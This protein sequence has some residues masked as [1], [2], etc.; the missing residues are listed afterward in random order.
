[1]TTPLEAALSELADIQRE[2]VEWR[3]GS[4]LVL[5][6][7]GSGK[8]QVLTCRI[9]SMLESSKGQNFRLLALTFTN[10]AADEMKGRVATFAPGLEDRANIG[11]FHSFCGQIL[12]QHGVHIGVSPDFAIYSA[13]DDRKAVLHDALR[14]AQAEGKDA[15]P[16]DVKY[17][18]LIDRMK[19]RLID[20]G[21]AEAVL[22]R[23]VDTKRAV[24]TYLLY[25]E[26]LRRINALDFNSLIFEAYRLVTTYPAIA[27]RYHR[28]YPYWLVDEFQDTNSAQYKLLRALAGNE[29]RNLFAVADDDQIIYEWNG[30]SY[31]QIQSFLTDFSAEVIQLPTNYRCPP[32]IVEAANR[33]VVY[34][35]QRTAT[36]KPL[37]AGKT[38]VKYPVEE[39]I[40]LRQFETDEEEALKITREIA[41]RGATIWGQT[42][43]LARTRALL[44]RMHKALQEREVPSVIAQRRDDFLSAEFRWLVAALRQIARPLDRRNVAGLVEAFN[45]L[46]GI[47]VS[48]EQ[49][50]TDAET[51]GRGYLTTWIETAKTQQSL[52]TAEANLIDLISPCVSDPA[53]VKPAIE[54][55]LGEFMKKLTGPDAHSDLGEDIAAWKELSRDIS[56]HIGKNA[57]LDQFLQELQMRSK[58]PTPKPD[59]VTLMTIHGAKG[60]EFDFVYVIGLAEDVMPSFQSKQKGDRSPEMEEE[61]RNCFVAITRTKECLVLSRAESYRGWRK[62]PSR[63]L[64]EMGL[65]DPKEEG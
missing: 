7:P 45:R 21:S 51:T 60:R 62:A 14:R 17:L 9:A 52:E 31:K 58:E 49:V 57:P 54:S 34:N 23:Q 16:D 65:V 15:S 56:G 30:A 59:T 2:A 10:K 28:S 43:V 8:T 12:R 5:A 48:V 6:G 4:L 3:E 37:I 64:V 47:A 26:E 53:A 39:H 13:D 63:F 38:E 32:A 41:E 18:G 55:I 29:F 42:T 20:P 61:R 33:L 24:A 36:K 27:A 22:S 25:E 19:S 44:E 50:I 46:V 35:A 40:Q 11:T 1:M